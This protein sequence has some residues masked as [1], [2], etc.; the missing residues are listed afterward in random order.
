MTGASQPGSNVRYLR[1]GVS[2]DSDAS[3]IQE[4]A[5]RDGQG[6]ID[7]DAIPRARACRAQYHVLPQRGRGGRELSIG[8]KDMVMIGK[9]SAKQGIGPASAEEINYP[10]RA[11]ET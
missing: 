1:I 4:H 9:G 2:R 5:V 11:I 10:A 6:I 7:N 8:K 3:G